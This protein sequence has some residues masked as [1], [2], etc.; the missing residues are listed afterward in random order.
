MS[1]TFI[2]NKLLT[3]TSANSKQQQHM[4]DSNAQACTFNSNQLVH[5]VTVIVFDVGFDGTEITF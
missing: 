4:Q 3:I 2:S 1:S 5:L